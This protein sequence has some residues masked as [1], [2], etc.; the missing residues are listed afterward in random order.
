MGWR[1]CQGSGMLPAP[2][3]RTETRPELRSR[4]EGDTRDKAAAS[5]QGEPS[6]FSRI[7]NISCLMH[8]KCQ[9]ATQERFHGSS[10]QSWKSFQALA[11]FGNPGVATNT[12]C[13]N[14]LFILPCC[15]IAGSAT[16]NCPSRV[17]I[18]FAP[19]RDFTGTAGTAGKGWSSRFS[20]HAQYLIITDWKQQ[21]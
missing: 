12:I 11:G 13:K 18:C 14:I 8:I 2:P 10:F 1:R 20:C 6:A 5:T 19:F 4:L 15:G 16:Q 3:A 17:P 21:D 9:S 7:F